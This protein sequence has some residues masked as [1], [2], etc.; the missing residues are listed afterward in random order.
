MDIS[1]LSARDLANMVDIVDFAR[2]LR[3]K[4]LSREASMV[5]LKEV[6]EKTLPPFEL[7]EADEEVNMPVPVPEQVPEQ[8]PQNSGLMPPPPIMIGS[9]KNS[10]YVRA[11]MAGK[12]K[13][14]E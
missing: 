6:P 1:H 2:Q 4:R 9:G 11:L 3:Q 5:K 12:Y 10:G 8:V 13:T 14:P 7:L